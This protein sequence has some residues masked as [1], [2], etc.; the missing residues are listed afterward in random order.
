MD[1]TALGDGA[2]DFKYLHVATSSQMTLPMHPVDVAAEEFA[3]PPFPHRLAY[4]QKRE[5]GIGTNVAITLTYPDGSTNEFADGTTG[6]EVAE[7]IGARLAK[8]AVAV[9]LD[10]Q[11]YDL[12]RP[13]PSSGVFSVITEN[14]EEGRHVMRHSAAHIMAQAVLDLFEG[15]TFAIGPA[16]TDG[17]YYDFDIGR[18]FHPDDLEAIEARMAEI[19]AED[20]P[21]ERVEMSEEQAL[22]VFGDQ[23]FKTEIIK[24]VGAADLAEEVAPGDGLTVYKN[25]GFV[26]LC[27][28]PHLPSTGRLK[29][30]KLLRSAGA[31]WRGDENN[32][33]LQRIYGTA[34]ESKRALDDYLERLEEAEKRDHRKL[35]PELDLFSFPKELGAGLAVWHPEGG[36]IRKVMED[37]SRRLHEKYG[38]DFVFSPTSPKRSSGRPPGTST[39][40]RRTCTRRWRWTVGRTTGSNR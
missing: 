36:Q 30:V 15:A 16:I 40:T 27:R 26:D 13:L 3:L 14:S 4:W 9:K 10:D 28:G 2:N 35:G 17:F 33:Q 29:A 34:W 1:A 25:L 12:H 8:A 38:F 11:E 23:P 18:P 24:A 6:Y 20:Q 31:Y 39:S 7:R 19:V 32:A 37:H 5:K 22:A 21:F